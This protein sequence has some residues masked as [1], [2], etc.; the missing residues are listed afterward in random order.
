MSLLLLIGLMTFA[1]FVLLFN[2]N[3]VTSCRTFDFTTARVNSMDLIE[4]P[5]GSS[6]SRECSL[7]FVIVRVSMRIAVFFVLAF[8]PPVH[9]EVFLALL[10]ACWSSSKRVAISIINSLRSGLSLTTVFV[11]LMGVLS[12]TDFR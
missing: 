9:V 10:V 4:P 7:E 11:V 8:V 5:S 6:G 3:V 1:M 2:C 12:N